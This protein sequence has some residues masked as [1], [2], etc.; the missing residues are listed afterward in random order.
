MPVIKPGE[1][2]A[3]CDASNFPPAVGI[4]GDKVLPKAAHQ[5]PTNKFSSAT[6]KFTVPEWEV[7]ISDLSMHFVD[8]SKW[9][10]SIS[11][12][13]SVP[14]ELSEE[15]KVPPVSSPKLPLFEVE[16]PESVSKLF[17]GINMDTLEI[18]VPVCS[19][20]VPA[21]K[22]DLPIYAAEEVPNAVQNQEVR[23][24]PVCS[25]PVPDFSCDLPNYA[26]EEVPNAVQ[27]QEVRVLPPA[28]QCSDLQ[29]TTP[30]CKVPGLLLKVPEGDLSYI[31]VEVS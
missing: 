22:S 1:P 24:L 30:K 19:A 5:V 23:V 21:I 29:L 9:S 4:S 3:N 31:D 20:P 26:A 15:V 6:S 28:H 13:L 14:C 7:P 25:A 8:E 16:V 10:K 12:L 17:D 18:E 27:N 11:E 2:F